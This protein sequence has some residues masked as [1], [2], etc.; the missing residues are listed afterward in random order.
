MKNDSISL[1]EKVALARASKKQ[2]N[3]ANSD[4][5]GLMG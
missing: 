2:V 4:K 3:T 5:L 1:G